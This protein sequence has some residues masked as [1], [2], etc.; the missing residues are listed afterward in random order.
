MTAIYSAVRSGLGLGYSPLWQ[1]KQLVETEGVQ[2][3]MENFEPKPVPI[4]ALWHENKL[5]P[6]KIRTLV[7]NLA[8]RLRLDDL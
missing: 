5:P 7:D 4:D 6:A 2:I 1:I 3:V 8:K